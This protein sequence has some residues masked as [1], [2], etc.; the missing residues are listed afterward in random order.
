MAQGTAPFESLAKSPILVSATG[1][2]AL[3]FDTKK[4][5]NLLQRVSS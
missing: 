4:M 5:K 3:C 1:L 2:K